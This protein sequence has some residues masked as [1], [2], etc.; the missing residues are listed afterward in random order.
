[1]KQTLILFYFYLISLNIFAQSNNVGIGTLSP[2]QSSILELKST[3]QGLLV[4]RLTTA[5]RL[6]ITSPSNSLLVY[7]TDFE[8]FYYAKN[9]VWTSLCTSGGITGPTGSTG[10]TGPQ[11]LQGNSGVTGAT[12]PTGNIGVTGATGITGNTGSTGNTGNTG[13]TGNTGPTGPTG[14]GATGATGVQGNT[15]VTGSTGLTGPT[16]AGV[17]G[18]TGDTGPSGTGPTGPTGAGTT[19]PTGPTGSSG[20]GA[21]GPTGPTGSGGT[22]ATGPTGPTGN[23]GSAGATGP[24]GPTGT[25]SGNVFSITGTTDISMNSTTYATALT[26]NFT[27]TK[28][29]VLAM[30]TISGR[31]NP[32]AY[33]NQNVYARLL[34]N[35]TAIGGA[36]SVGEDIDD[37]GY[38]VTTWNITFSKPVS[39]TPNVPNTLTL[40]WKRDGNFTTTIYCEPIAQPTYG[41]RTVTAIEY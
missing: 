24:T 11:G 10:S 7:D 1:M 29:N 13:V 36:A 37:Y 25:G 21:T 5:E 9:T 22:G 14:F 2:D 27:P 31:S 41:H 38:I 32:S 17:T 40:E 18:P 3:T 15:G 19:G 39:V 35:G 6:A 23:N 33:P 8:C 20:T 30:F 28:S 12:G 34:L 4:P 26:L 16:G